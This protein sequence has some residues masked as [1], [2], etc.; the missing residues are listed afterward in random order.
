MED[1]LGNY[2]GLELAHSEADPAVASLRMQGG[3]LGEFVYYQGF[4][5]PIKIWEVLENENIIVREE[6]VRK[7]GEWGEF[8]DLELVK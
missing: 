6:F 7:V 5:G 8:D 2:D 4:R 3:D 1:A